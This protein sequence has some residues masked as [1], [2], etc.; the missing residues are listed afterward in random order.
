ML[1][2]SDINAQSWTS[3]RPLASWGSPFANVSTI[4]VSTDIIMTGKNASSLRWWVASTVTSAF[5][6]FTEKRSTRYR[7]EIRSHTEVTLRS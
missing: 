1:H 3:R 4:Y 2:S 7:V 5:S 6:K